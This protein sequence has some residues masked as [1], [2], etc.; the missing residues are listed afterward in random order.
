MKTL[1]KHLLFKRVR[2]TRK[3]WEDTS[4]QTCND[5][6]WQAGK[7]TYAWVYHKI[8]MNDLYIQLCEKCFHE[9]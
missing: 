5:D 2:T 1:T 3:D 4:C 8:F 9:L 7:T 6:L